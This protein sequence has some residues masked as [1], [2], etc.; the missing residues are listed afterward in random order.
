MNWAFIDL[1]AQGQRFESVI[2]HH[3]QKGRKPETACGLFFIGLKTGLLPETAPTPCRRSSPKR[4]SPASG[5]GTEYTRA[6]Y[7]LSKS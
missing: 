6:W 5:V 7:S 3:A 1:H 2:A 4:Y